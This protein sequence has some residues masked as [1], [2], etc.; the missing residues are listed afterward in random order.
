ME[1]LIVVILQLLGIGFHV[2]QKIIS[3]GDKNP[4]LTSSDVF[5]AFLF[6]DWDTLMVSALVLALNIVAHYIIENYTSL[7]DTKNF[8]IYAFGIAFVLGYAGQRI[9]YK[10]L[11][12]AESFLNKKADVLKD[13]E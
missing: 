4:K 8:H 3:L 7:C 9:V 5:S 1:Y 10:Y 11:G 13:K 12:S 6:E 2:M